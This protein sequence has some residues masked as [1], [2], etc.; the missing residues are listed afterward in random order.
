MNLLPT[1][2][3]FGGQIT[4]PGHHISLVRIEELTGITFKK[5]K[6][7]ISGLQP[8]AVEG[9]AHF[10]DARAVLPLLYQ[11]DRSES[12]ERPVSELDRERARLASAQADK[13]EL[14]VARIIGTYVLAAELETEVARVFSAIRGKLLSL[15]TRAAPLIDGLSAVDSEAYLKDLVCEV[16]EELARFDLGISPT[17]T[18]RVSESS[19]SLHP[20]TETESLPVG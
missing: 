3:L 15:P 16:L 4:R 20:T 8:E 12:S 7:R 5:I 9:T 6:K 10:Y 1:Q 2:D 13:T 19:G 14:E 11:D 18:D 17:G